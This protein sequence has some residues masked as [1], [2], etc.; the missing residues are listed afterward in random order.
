ML[1][2]GANVR[3]GSFP[4][5]CSDPRPNVRN[6]WITAA[7]LSFVTPGLT[8]GPASS[9]LEA[10]TNEWKVALV[11]RSNPEWHDLYDQIL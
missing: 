8:R 9:V 11:E 1:I 6:G 2:E 5:V 10:C 4:D 7:G 3:N